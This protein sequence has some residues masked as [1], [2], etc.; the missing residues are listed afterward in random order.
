MKD[1]ACVRI[2]LTVVGL[3]VVLASTIWYKAARANRVALFSPSMAIVFP[4]E[5]TGFAPIGFAV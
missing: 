4:S 2:S 5:L 3:W 1:S